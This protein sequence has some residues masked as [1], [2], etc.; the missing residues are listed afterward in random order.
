MIIANAARA[1]ASTTGILSEEV[2]ADAETPKS[3][4]LPEVVLREDVEDSEEGDDKSKDRVFVSV[5]EIE[6]TL[7]F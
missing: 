2:I 5:N 4:V 6:G 3:Q 1:K 7:A